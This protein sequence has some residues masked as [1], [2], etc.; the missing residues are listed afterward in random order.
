MVVSTFLEWLLLGTA[1]GHDPQTWNT[2]AFVAW[3]L[4]FGAEV[5]VRIV[6]VKTLISMSA[7]KARE[8]AGRPAFWGVGVGDQRRK[9]PLE[10]GH[11]ESGEDL[12]LFTL[13]FA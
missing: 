8:K 1:P 6:A 5:V 3:M 7:S 11:R 2:A 13:G 12:P 10:S 4:P 9:G